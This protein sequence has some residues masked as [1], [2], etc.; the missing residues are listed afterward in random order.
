M[1]SIQTSALLFCLFVGLPIVTEAATPSP[2]VITKKETMVFVF[3]DA[4]PFQVDSEY[5]QCAQISAS[6]QYAY[7]DNPSHTYPDDFFPHIGPNVGRPTNELAT[8]CFDQGGPSGETTENQKIADTLNS[9]V[10]TNLAHRA[11]YF[12]SRG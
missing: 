2:S 3:K 9:Y 10:V 4:A 11:P 1:K 7:H 12:N 5:D 8:E 6:F